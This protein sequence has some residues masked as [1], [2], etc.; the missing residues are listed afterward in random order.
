MKKGL[1]AEESTS[2]LLDEEKLHEFEDQGAQFLLFL[3]LVQV[4]SVGYFFQA[5]NITF[6]VLNCHHVESQEG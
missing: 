2:P 5:I 3:E 6:H 4:Q 1:H